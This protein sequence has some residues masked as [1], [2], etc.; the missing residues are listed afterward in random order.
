MTQQLKGFVTESCEL[1]QFVETPV[2][3]QS[4]SNLIHRV[5]TKPNVSDYNVML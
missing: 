1:E 2:V 3:G 4:Y 5:S